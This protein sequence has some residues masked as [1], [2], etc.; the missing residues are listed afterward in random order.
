M[1]SSTSIN[2]P[3]SCGISC[4]IVRPRPQSGDCVIA[5]CFSSLTHPT[6]LIPNNYFG[7]KEQVASLLRTAKWVA[8]NGV[9]KA[10]SQFQAARDAL[11]R[12]PPRI[13]GGTVGTATVGLS[14]LEAAKKL[15]LSLDHSILP[16]QGPPGSGKTFTGAH[17]VIELVNAGSASASLPIVTR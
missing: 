14:P 15:A 5:I 17:M 3:K 4:A 6:A 7:S 12:L 9:D 1:P 10:D 8:D 13:V 2:P 11:L 16:I